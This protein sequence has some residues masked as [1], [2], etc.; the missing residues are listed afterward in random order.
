MEWELSLEEKRKQIVD[1]N[2]Y[3][4]VS[5]ITKIPL[6]KLNTNEKADLL[7]IEDKLK[8]SVIGQDTAIEKIAKSIRRNRTGIR[9]HNKPIGTFMFLG[10]TG[11]GKTHLSKA[12]AK[13]LF[14]SEDA[15]IRV[16]MS[17][18]SEKFNA[19]RL[20]GSPPGYVGYQQGG[21]LT[22]AVRN[23]PYSVVLFDEI[24]KSH[25]DIFD[26]MLQIFDEGHLTDGLGR[27][28][29]FK[30]TLIIMTS[31][32]GSRQLH[33]FGRGLGFKTES[34][35]QQRAE[36]EKQVINKALK[37]RFSPEFLNRV[38]ETVIFNSLDEEQVSKIAEI[39]LNNLSTR[40]KEIGYKFKFTKSVVKYISS[41][42]FD[43]N[44]GARPIKRTIQNKIEDYLSE[45]VLKGNI[46]KDKSYT[47]SFTKKGELSL[48]SR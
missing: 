38:D 29:N 28:V 34:K 9:A 13:E 41:E 45:E 46:V 24:E 14:G 30:N 1:E 18:Y 48:K 44:Y 37:N 20:V 23:K 47:L 35:D 12:I 10:S 42:G 43:E 40:L 32:V 5:Q 27:K 39:E 36:E 31:N 7:K 8:L 15:L 33:D 21:Q 2:I 6:T 11:I 25:R 4:V 22:E 16:D 17:E 26:L 19:S 3:A